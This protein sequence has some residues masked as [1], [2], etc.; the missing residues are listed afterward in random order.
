LTFAFVIQAVDQSII[1]FGDSVCQKSANVKSMRNLIS[2]LCNEKIFIFYSVQRTY[3]FSPTIAMINAQF[4][5]SQILSLAP[6][7]KC[8]TE[9]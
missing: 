3:L 1:E 4:P 7:T 6:I 2:S 8:R 9:Y 5:L